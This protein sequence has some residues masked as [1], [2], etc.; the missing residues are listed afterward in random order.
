MD[1]SHL[2]RGDWF[3]TETGLKCGFCGV[4]NWGALQKSLATH[5]IPAV[6]L[7]VPEGQGLQ[8]VEPDNGGVSRDYNESHWTD[9]FIDGL[10][11]P[12][13]L[14]HKLV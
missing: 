8:L 12:L 14:G 6:S 13:S 10:L 9:W 4:H 11:R 7:Y 2:D 3:R 1:G 5:Y